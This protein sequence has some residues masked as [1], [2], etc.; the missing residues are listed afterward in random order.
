M[1]LIDTDP[2]PANTCHTLEPTSRLGS[3]TAPAR[4]RWNSARIVGMTSPPVVG[5]LNRTAA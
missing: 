1:P 5:L 4:N 3:L 2:L